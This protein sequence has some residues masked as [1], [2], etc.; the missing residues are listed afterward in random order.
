MDHPVETLYGKLRGQLVDREGTVYVFK[1]VPYAQPPKGP[2]RFLAPQPPTPWVGVRDAD[3]F[4]PVSMQNTSS[5]DRMLGAKPPAMSEDCLTLNIWTPGLD[6]AKRPVMVWVHGGSFLSGSSRAPWYDGSSFARNGDVVVVTIN[7]RLG[8]L[9]FLSLGIFDERYASSGNTGLRDQIA[10]LHWVRDNIANF[11]GNPENVTVFGESAGAMSIGALFGAEP[12]QD[13]FH[14]AIFQSGAPDHVISLEQSEKVTNQFLAALGLDPKTRVVD[15]LRELSSE[16]ILEAQIAVRSLHRETG[17]P[18]RPVL[19]GLVINADPFTA[20]E[21]GGAA[22]VQLLAGTNLDE[23]RFFTLFDPTVSQLTDDTLIERCNNRYGDRYGASLVEAYRDAR[24]SLSAAQCWAAIAT[25]NVFRLP[26]RKLLDAHSA[27]QPMSFG[28]LFSWETPAFAGAL[29][30]SHVLEIPFVF[31]NLD[32]PG[33]KALCGDTTEAMSQLASK[34]HS[35]WISF[36]HNGNPNHAGIPTW[37]SHNES[38]RA[39]MVFDE[40]CDT[41]DD[42]GGQALSLLDEAIESLH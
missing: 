39:A 36:A 8:A 40:Y 31:D 10:A 22:K 17:M 35:S 21:Q 9:G 34:M 2:L 28:Y 38:A 1:G 12:A 42:P 41:K 13:L 23:M 24:P 15:R 37:P 5:I 26:T 16:A 27:H 29:G 14:K 19:D 32:Q 25:D 18:W 4:S 30:S 33:V 7:Y 20:I 3:S 11:G 6:N